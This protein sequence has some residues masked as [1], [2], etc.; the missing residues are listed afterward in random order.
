MATNN[1]LLYFFEQEDDEANWSNDDNEDVTPVDNESGL[2]WNDDGVDVGHIKGSEEVD[3]EDS[4]EGDRILSNCESDDRENGLLSEYEDEQTF[5]YSK[6]NHNEMI[7]ITI[8]Q[9]FDNVQHFKRV[10]QNHVL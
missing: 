9:E 2:N 5:H 7:G 8:G 10:L 6:S 3:C 4:E 1:G